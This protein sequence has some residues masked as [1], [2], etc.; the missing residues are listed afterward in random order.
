M[1]AD[2][3]EKIRLSLRRGYAT[4]FE[5]A[6]K[7]AKELTVI[8]ALLR[9]ME[10]RGEEKYFGPVQLPSSG[11]PPDGV[12]SDR[13]GNPVAVEVTELVSR[14][15]IEKNQTKKWEEHA[16]RDWEPPETIKKINRIIWDWEPPEVIREISRIIKKKDGKTFHGGPYAKKIL[17][18]FTDEYT[19]FSSR[20]E[21]AKLLPKR[22]FGPVKQID[23]AYFLFS[24]AGSDEGY[25]YIKLSLE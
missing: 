10:S 20:F 17:V 24:Y 16:Y 3:I 7:Q 12:V 23:E 15:A 18:I 14:R 2:C 4:Y 19:L 8:E 13:A 21:Y 25:P 5:G 9:S 22:S 11:D 6:D 1:K